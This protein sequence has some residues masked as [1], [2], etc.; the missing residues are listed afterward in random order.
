MKGQLRRLAQLRARVDASVEQLEVGIVEARDE[1]GLSYR[2]IGEAAGLS[3]TEAR[4]IV[5]RRKGSAA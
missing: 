3:H 1:L 5:A 4:R 2:T